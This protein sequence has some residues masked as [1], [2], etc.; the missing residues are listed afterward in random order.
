[1]LN[2]AG[3]RADRVLAPDEIIRQVKARY[4]VCKYLFNAAI[5][6]ILGGLL[7][8][9]IAFFQND[10]NLA[11]SFIRIFL[12]SEA[13]AL[14]IFSVAFALTLAIYRCPVCDRYL[15]PSRPSK[16]RCPRCKAQVRQA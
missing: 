15:S 4:R 1:M 12:G 16:L 7:S 6:W 3:T 11:R 9:V 8:F 14:A 10:A 13:C 5:I 2:Q